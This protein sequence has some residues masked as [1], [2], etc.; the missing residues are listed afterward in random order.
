KPKT[1][2]YPYEGKLVF[3]G[4]YEV[5]G[6]DLCICGDSVDT[7]QEKNPEGRRP[8]EFKSSKGLLLVF[9]RE[10]AEQPKNEPDKQSADQD[11]AKQILDMVLKGLQ[12]YQDSKG[13]KSADQD[14][15][16]FLWDIMEKS[17]RPQDGKKAGPAEREALDLYKEAFMR[18]FQVAFQVSSHMAKTT[19][20]NQSTIKPGH[21]ATS[22]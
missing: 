6:D 17:Y 13:K 21:Q 16:K 4:I 12:A 22:K 11:Q 15:A 19:K 3:Y 9:R 5:K 1:V 14:L 8:K 2:T 20:K 10:K 7:A 18:A